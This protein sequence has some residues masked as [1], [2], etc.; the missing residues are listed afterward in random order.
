MSAPLHTR[1]PDGGLNDPDEILDR[2]LAWV[3]ETGFEPYAEQDEA[4]L[5]LVLGRHVVLST[6]TGSGK[7]LV[8]QALHF[9]ALCEG[10]RSFYT[11]PV[12]ALASEKFFE[13]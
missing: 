2:F 5:E 11:S 7:S 4:F 12:K 8:A 9:K 1:I 10:R 6:P 3:H 13:W